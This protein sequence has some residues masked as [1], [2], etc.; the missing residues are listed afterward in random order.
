MNT[1]AVALL[2]LEALISS[3]SAPL[4][5]PFSFFVEGVPPTVVHFDAGKDGAELLVFVTNREGTSYGKFPNAVFDEGRPN[6]VYNYFLPDTQAGK[7][8]VVKISVQQAEKPGDPFKFQL[9]ASRTSLK[10]QKLIRL[11]PLPKTEEAVV[12]GHLDQM[13]EEKIAEA[14]DHLD[15][16]RRKEAAKKPGQPKIT[17]A[18]EMIPA[19][20]SLVTALE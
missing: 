6:A 17:Q 11:S 16:V 8:S 15:D 4:G 19:A 7:Q 5:T 12:K 3:T 20:D 18:C 14:E 9:Q 13:I 1:T 2:C 10:D